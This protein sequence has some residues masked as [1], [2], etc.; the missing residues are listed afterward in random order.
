MN[1]KFLRVAALCVVLV[2][3]ATISLNAT[4]AQGGQ[5]FGSNW[6]AFYWDNQIFAGNPKFS[7]VDAAINFNWQWNSP[8]S[9]IP[10]DHF[11]ARWSSTFTFAAGTYRFSVGADDGARVAIDGN[12]IINRWSDAVGGFTVNNAD[13]ALGAGSH[14]IVVDYYD[15]VGDA[16]VQFYWSTVTGG[17]GPI[18]TSGP[19]PTPTLPPS[20]GT[21]PVTQIHAVVIVDLANVRS[22]PSTTFTP[23][24]QVFLNQDFRVVAQNGL[25]TWFLIQ[26]PDGRRGWIFRRMIYL[27]NGDWTKIPV[28]T[29][30]VEPQASLVDVRGVARFDVMVRNGP[31]TRGAKLGVIPEGSEFRVLRLSRNRAWVFVNFEGLEGWVF[32]VNVKIVFGDLGKLPVGN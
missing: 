19:T 7:R 1:I 12:I 11:S 21:L 31:S 30:P 6:L 18:P 17:T 2:V 27:Y 5:D 32:I 13:V 29:V 14:Q 25:N 24:T 15:N 3:T 23:I 22:G 8:D 16:G 9:S 28:L 4:R 26:L 20:P 10:A